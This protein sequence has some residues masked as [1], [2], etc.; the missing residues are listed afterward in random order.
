MQLARQRERPHTLDYIHELCTEFVELHGD[1]GFREDAALVGG[2]AHFAGR[3]VM[4]LGHQK[5]T[6]AKENVQRHFGMAHPEGYHKA[7]RLMLQ[8]EKFGFPLLTFID[9]PGA[10]PGLASEERGQAHAIAACIQALTGLRVP[11]VA[12][13]IGEGGSGGALALGVADEVLMLENAIYT[14]ASPEAAAS[15]LFRDSAQAPA[16]AAAM[17]ITAADLARFGLVDRVIPERAPA[18]EDP[19]PTIVAVGRAIRAAL[20]RL[21]AAYDLA[22]PAGVDALLAARYEKF[23]AMGRWREA[24][25]D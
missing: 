11:I 21:E 18:H 7:H 25:A 6:N 10:D 9:T 1:R 22:T 19:L 20:D 24:T 14:V 4:V 23:S 2:P 8:A 13:V 12:T 3:T 16:A 17:R 5:G 15:I